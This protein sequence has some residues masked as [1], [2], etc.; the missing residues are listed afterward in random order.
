MFLK[1]IPNCGS[2]PIECSHKAENTM[3]EL[4]EEQRLEL[5]GPEPARV[6]DPGTRQRYVLVREELFERMRAVFDDGSLDSAQ[7]G[8]LVKE[9]MRE[10]A[11]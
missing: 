3:I 5:R 4:N 1:G 11:G 8:K 10:Y 6:L 9:T 7:V 2:V